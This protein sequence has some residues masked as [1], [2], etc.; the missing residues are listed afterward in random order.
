MERIFKTIYAGSHTRMG[1]SK[2][3][4]RVFG[5]TQFAQDRAIELAKAKRER[6]A[7]IRSSR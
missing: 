2:I 7:A 6:K 4:I 1:R 5:Q 3:V